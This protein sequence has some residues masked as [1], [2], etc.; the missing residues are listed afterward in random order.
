MKKTFE[1]VLKENREKIRNK[2]KEEIKR[3][4]SERM[5][6]TILTIF[7]GLFIVSTTL[8][9]LTKLD[10]KMIED[11]TNAGHSQYYCEKGIE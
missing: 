3:I 10:N 9:I 11:C 2:R 8:F 1:E 6:E 5:K 4:K 7:I